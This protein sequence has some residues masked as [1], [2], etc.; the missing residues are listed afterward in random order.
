MPGPPSPTPSPTPSPGSPPTPF[1][2][3]SVL[4][5]E[6]AWAGTRA[7]ANDEWIE[8]YNPGP[9]PVPLSGWTLTDQNDI[10]IELAGVLDAGAYFLLERTDD[11]TVSGIPADLIY[12]RRP[13]E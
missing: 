10:S 3:Y 2:P 13:G 11:R 1:P 7:S 5:N 8:L 12:T 6:V 9:A 4:I